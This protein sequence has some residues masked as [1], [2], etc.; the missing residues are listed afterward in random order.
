LNNF[1]NNR[2]NYYSYY[3]TSIWNSPSKI[4][5]TYNGSEFE[6]YLGNYWDDYTGRDADKDGI[7]DIPYTI[8]LSDEDNYPLIERFEN[9]F[10]GAEKKYKVHNINTYEDFLTIQ[11]AIDDLDTKDGHTITVDLGTYYE[12]VRVY[13]SLT[14]KSTSGNPEDTFVWAKNSDAHVFLITAD[15]VNITGFTVERAVAPWYAGI[16][17]Y[18]V[19]DCIIS[20]NICSNNAHGILLIASTNNDIINNICS[21]NSGVGIYLQS[22]SNANNILN[23]FCS[24]NA[25]NGI[26]LSSSNNNNIINNICSNNQITSYTIYIMQILTNQL[27]QPGGPH[28][29]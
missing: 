23:N 27:Q 21:D 2:K 24:N 20:N 5:Y 7:R 4:T 19:C 18:Y 22:F 6:N 9:Y 8:Y 26:D 1:I 16:R 14:I 3:S 29:K 25:Q 12:N 13:K 10:E 28:Q 11:A 15:C 17:L